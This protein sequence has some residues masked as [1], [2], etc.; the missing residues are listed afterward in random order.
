MKIKSILAIAILLTSMIIAGISTAGA[1]NTRNDACD[2]PSGG[3]HAYPPTFLNN[4]VS[5]TAITVAPGQ[6]FPVTIDW[7]GGVTSVTN[8]VAKWPSGVLDNALFSPNP[9]ISPVGVFA[10][11]T[12]TSTLTAPL[13]TGTYTLRAYTSDGTGS[14]NTFRETD[15]KN[16]AVTVQA[17]A[18][19]L[20]SITVSPPAAALSIGGAQSFNATALDQNGAPMSGITITWESNNTPVGNVAP[21]TAT[22]DSFGNAITKFTAS[23]AGVAMVTATNGTTVGSANVTVI[24]APPALKT[25]TVSPPAAALSIG[26]AQSFNATALD[27]NGAPMSGITITWESNNTPVGNVAPATSTTDSFGNAITKFTASTAGAAMVT[28]T[29]GTVVGSANV[30]VTTAPVVAKIVISKITVFVGTTVIFS[31]QAYDQF[32]NPV[33]VALTWTS[34]NTTV[35]TIDPTTG[36]FI[37]KAIGITTI[38]ATD[39]SVVGNADVMVISSAE[40]VLDTITVLPATASLSVN[41]TQVFTA[42]AKD[43]NSIPIAGINI[44]WNSDNTTVGTVDQPNSVTDGNGSAITTFTAAAL[45]TATITAANGSVVGSANVIVSPALPELTTITVSPPTAALSI[46]GAQSFDA[47]ALDQNGAP[48]SGIRITWE[49][50]NTP[51]GN[52]DPATAT[53]DVTGKATTTFTAS[54]AGVAM[55]TATNGTVVGSAN[56]IVTSQPQEVTSFLLTP[57]TMVALKGDN[58]VITVTAMNGAVPQPLFNGM[59]NITITAINSSAV[60]VTPQPV[61]FT[62][63]NATMNVSSSIAQFV[64]VTATSDTITGSTT[65]EFADLVIPLV[66]GWNLVSIPSFANPSDT[67]NALQL[68]QNNGVQTFDPAT[69]MF[70]TPTDLQPLF[71]YWINVTADN[72]KLGFIADTSVIIIP[73]ARNLYEGW[74]LIGVSANRSEAPADITNAT[75]VDLRNGELPSQWLYSRLISFDG[76]NPQTFTAGVDLTLDSPPLKQGHGYWL[77][78]KSIPN[79]NKNNVPWA[80]KLW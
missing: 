38:S 53:T 5:I 55:V 64:T 7:T 70:L 60:E 12:L 44:N 63:G 28:A 68:V 67:T 48:M 18:P 62:M 36:K 29:N 75:F 52:V 26:G 2:T 14:P 74:N 15:Y 27:Q 59:A 43:Q 24:T 80:G 3:C 35:G 32:N 6:S 61:T 54:A 10:T 25:I 8:T 13:T 69:M 51:V 34:S 71:G 17:P 39:G 77:F 42:T 57:E 1:F 31:A 49:S 22:T 56:V 58:I 47:T 21:A 33:N 4:T 19:V 65:V 30:T 66:K 37:A 73:P 40:S 9:V 79:T 16:I 78:I 20:T 46:G 23:A 45:G 41:G 50:N 11:G 76:A 72:Q